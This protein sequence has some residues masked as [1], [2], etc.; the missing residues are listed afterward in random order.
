M[1]F[2]STN[3]L[4]E[5]ST[6]A[7]RLVYS[8]Q[9]LGLSRAECSRRTGID[10]SYL[11]AWENERTTPLLRSIARLSRFFGWGERHGTPEPLCGRLG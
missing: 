5:P 10:E 7:E 8:R 1:E 3:P 6:F 11:A 2:L 9:S 4:P